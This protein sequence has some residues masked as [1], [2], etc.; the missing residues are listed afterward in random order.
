M[1]AEKVI[2]QK[3]GQVPLS[4]VPNQPDST[5]IGLKARVLKVVFNFLKNSDLD[6]EIYDRLET[7]RTRHSIERNKLF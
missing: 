1:M 6:E 7:K 3:Q 2:D 4:V 5:A